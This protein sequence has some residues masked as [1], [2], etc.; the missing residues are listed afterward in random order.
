MHCPPTMEPQSV[1]RVLPITF[2]TKSYVTMEVIRVG[3]R[4]HARGRHRR[5][6]L[7]SV[8][9]IVHALV[10]IHLHLNNNS[11]SVFVVGF[12]GFVE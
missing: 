6:H 1:K 10:G 9:R 11:V 3:R 5:V 4:I 7:V 2:R 12:F 8:C